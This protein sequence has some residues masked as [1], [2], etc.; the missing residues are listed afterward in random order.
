MNYLTALI[1]IY[2][3]VFFFFSWCPITK[4]T[5]GPCFIFLLWSCLFFFLIAIQKHSLYKIHSF[6]RCFFLKQ[7]TKES[8]RNRFVFSCLVLSNVQ[9]I[10]QSGAYEPSHIYRVYLQQ[11]ASSHACF[12]KA[13]NNR[14]QWR[15]LYWEK[16]LISHVVFRKQTWLGRVDRCVI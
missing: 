7:L 10:L 15:T 1:Y 13:K 5:K 2:V 11:P 6:S 3:K 4:S 16:D 8:N 14:A 9:G 12:P